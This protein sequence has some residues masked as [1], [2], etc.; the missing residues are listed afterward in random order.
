[1]TNKFFE[2]DGLKST[3]KTLPE[4]KDALLREKFLKFHGFKLES[5]K[6]L[7]GRFPEKDEIFF[8]WTVNSFNAFTFIPYT[9]K[10]SGVIEKLIISTYSI[11]SRIVDSLFNYILKGK[12]LQ[13]KILIS[14]SI[15][16]RMP[17]VVDHLDSLV[18]GNNDKISVIYDW[19][20]SKIT[21]IKSGDM[22]L[23]VEG[24]G[25]FSENAK[26]EQY[27][28]LNSPVVFDFRSKWILNETD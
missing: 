6:T 3:H 22:H 19:N 25:N 23:V 28:F 14:D 7:C 26:N 5:I 24:S 20:H 4:D 18:A 1:M 10:Y 27:I 8:I 17:R 16:Y 15:K 11:N 21:L 9:I 12:I 2:L 13:V